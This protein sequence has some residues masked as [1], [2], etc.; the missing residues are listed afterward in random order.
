MGTAV[1]DDP[2][3][4]PWALGAVLLIGSVIFG[5]VIFMM[6]R[7]V[8]RRRKQETMSETMSDQNQPEP[9]AEPV[10]PQEPDEQDPQEPVREHAMAGRAAVPS[11]R[12]SVAPSDAPSAGRPPARSDAEMERCWADEGIPPLRPMPTNVF[13]HAPVPTPLISQFRT[14]C[15]ECGGRGFMPGIN[16]LLQ[17]SVKLLG[18]EGDE[19][20]RLFYSALL[21]SHPQLITLFPGNPTQGEFGSDHK[22]AKQR[23]RLLKALTALADLYD[24]AEP[25]K[26]KHLDDALA[27]FGRSHASFARQDGTIRGATLEEYAAVK[28]ALFTTLMR[29][30]GGQWKPEYTEAWGQAYDYAAASMLTEQFRSGFA[31]PRFPRAGS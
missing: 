17:E 25:D 13:R 15:H 9:A 26:M 30:A 28:E 24:P 14:D 3:R 16:D 8:F 11:I 6:G 10:S 21:R 31:A 29:V 7:N 20:V 5:P 12:P 18:D 2:I 23:D 22:G 4:D 19:V 1:W 27:S